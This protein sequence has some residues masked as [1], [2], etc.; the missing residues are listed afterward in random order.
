MS[1]IDPHLSQ[2]LSPQCAALLVVDVQNDF[3]HRDGLFGKLGMDMKYVQRAAKQIAALLPAARVAGV[4][5]IFVNMEHSRETNSRAWLSRYPTTRA[6]ACLAGTWGA[7]LYEVQPMGDEP[8]VVKHR[9]SPFVGSNIEYLLRASD[10]KS[11]IVTGVATNICVEAV[12]RDGFARDYDVVLVDDCAGAYSER[13]HQST[14]D[15]TRAFL[16]RVVH[17]DELLKHWSKS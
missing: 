3:C 5:V 15:N 1:A 13:A 12:M 4:P 2:I 17:S 8:V 16:G 7:K 11:L 10:R 14:V 6:D 9:Y